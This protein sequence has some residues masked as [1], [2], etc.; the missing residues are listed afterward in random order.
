MATL[1]VEPDSERGRGQRWVLKDGTAELATARQV[2]LRSRLEVET[3]G[4]RLTV[5]EQRRPKGWVVVDDATDQK[6]LDLTYTVFHRREEAA[7]VTLS[8]GVRLAWT[9]RLTDGDRM[10]GFYD[11]TG[12]P[13]VVMS[14]HL[15][16]QPSA[17]RGAW[18]NL[19]SLWGSFARASD[20]F[21]IDVEDAAAA[22]LVR[23]E[24]LRTL[25]LLGAWLDMSTDW[26]HPDRSD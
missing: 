6:V 15:P 3:G 23:T 19:S 9:L 11:G 7:Q 2:G 13:V 1:V 20:Y 18:G 24:E 10:T 22:R 16:W 21:R 8:T 17:Q 14:H 26:R 4:R 12:A 5:R 25:V